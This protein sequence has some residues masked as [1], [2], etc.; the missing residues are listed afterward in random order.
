MAALSHDE[1]ADLL[2]GVAAA[3]E[4]PEQLA[5]EMGL[6]ATDLRSV[7]VSIR[8]AKNSTELARLTFALE[9]GFRIGCRHG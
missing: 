8:N 5:D 3:T 4:P 7:V 1:V 9:V 2:R 6:D